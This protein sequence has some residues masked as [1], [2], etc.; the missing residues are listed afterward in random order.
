[1]RR[2]ND[3]VDSVGYLA[4][5]IPRNRLNYLVSLCEETLRQVPGN[6]LEVGVYRGGSLVC[7]ADVVSRVSPE[8]CVFG[9]DTFTGHPYTDGHPIHP[10]GKYADIEVDT[11]IRS[12]TAR[13][14]DRWIKLIRGR[15]EH[16]LDPDSIRPLS[17]VHVDCDLYSPVLYCARELPSRIQRGGIIYFD[18]YGHEHCP[19]ATAAVREMFA[20][21]Q[22]TE[23]YMQE[24]ET[25]WSCFI[26]V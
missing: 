3:P 9:V 21:A 7:L 1:M 13:G 5:V 18:D 16:V 19:G 25:C 6:V 4:S 14:L 22:V 2:T 17:F 10:I 24:D 26:R 23:V 11:L 15:V 12:L 20:T 8:H